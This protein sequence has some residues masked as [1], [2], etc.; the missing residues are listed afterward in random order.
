VPGPDTAVTSPDG[1][2]TFVSLSLTVSGLADL[3]VIED[4]GDLDAEATGWAPAR[5]EAAL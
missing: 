1:T 5:R 3:P 4:A 2:T